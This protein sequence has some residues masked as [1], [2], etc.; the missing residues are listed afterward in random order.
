VIGCWWPYS[1]LS[2]RIVT[3]VEPEYPVEAWLAGEEGIV[4]L[5]VTLDSL[6]R[7]ISTTKE[8]GRAPFVEAALRTRAHWRLAA[9]DSMQGRAT[10]SGLIQFFFSV[11]ETAFSEDESRVISTIPQ[12][13][14]SHPFYCSGDSDPA[15]DRRYNSTV[16]MRIDSAG[17]VGATRFLGPAPPDS[18][19]IQES[20]REW[21]F[22]PFVAPDGPRAGQAI[23]VWVA[24]RVV[25]SC[26]GGRTLLARPDSAML[27][28]LDLAYGATVANLRPA[29]RRTRT[30]D[31]GDESPVR[32]RGRQLESSFA[33]SPRSMR[34]DSIGP[35]VKRIL[36][37]PG[38]YRGLPPTRTRLRPE[39]E[40]ALML[41][42]HDRARGPSATAT[43]NVLIS[44][45]A[46]FIQVISGKSV[47][48]L[49]TSAI[50]PEVQALVDDL[51]IG[52]RKRAA[53]GRPGGR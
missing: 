31:G 7:V 38:A 29:D 15:R 1:P 27:A 52:E 47:L 23:P 28:V 49:P 48:F 14:V 4:E 40:Y 10:R 22:R 46:D 8:D 20:A 5:R 53:V 25:R 43:V 45:A 50:K 33:V 39:P 36:E 6:G 18:V 26:S 44:P 16:A 2:P 35:R 51:F 19:A 42:K 37:N 41:R 17:F 32:L 9:E 3:R 21:I 30:I 11:D 12:P 24:V 34:G 13:L